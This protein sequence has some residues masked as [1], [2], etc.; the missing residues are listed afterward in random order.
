MDF[1]QQT[2]DPSTQSERDLP[3]SYSASIAYRR[4]SPASSIQHVASAQRGRP[5][6]PAPAILLVE[7]PKIPPTPPIKLRAGRVTLSSAADRSPITSRVHPSEDFQCCDCLRPY[8]CASHRITLPIKQGRCRQWEPCAEV[9][10][11]ALP[12]QGQ[13][14]EIWFADGRRTLW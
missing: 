2:P 4:S 7:T 9:S 10:V 13:G 12:K 8:T 6:H 5:A 11:S 1:L 3:H 14:K